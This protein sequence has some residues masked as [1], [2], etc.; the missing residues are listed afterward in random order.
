VKDSAACNQDKVTV[1]V[2]PDL[3]DLIPIFLERKKQDVDALNGALE[4]RDYETLRSVGHRI[5]GEGGG[6]GFD[7]ISEIG[8]ALE[9]A[10][11]ARDA[12]A[13]ERQVQA[14]ADYIGRVEVR[15][16]NGHA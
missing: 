7:V 13:A 2:D 12:G 11:R 15:F 1:E 5:K 14:L 6:Y 8:Q 9:E 10:G 3:E 16:P 4:R